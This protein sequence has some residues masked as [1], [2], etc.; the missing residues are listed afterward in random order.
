MGTNRDNPFVIHLWLHFLLLLF[1]I[2][3]VLI[4][5]WLLILA[6]FITEIVLWSGYHGYGDYH[7]AVMADE[8][9]QCS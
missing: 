5:R 2:A 3:V 1:A 6:D 4:A 7:S 8:S 9:S